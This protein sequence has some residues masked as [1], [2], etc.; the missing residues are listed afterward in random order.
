MRRHGQLELVL[1]LPDGGR[2]LIPA[3]WTDLQPRADGETDRAETLGRLDELKH[4]RL[5]VDS[6]LRRV[7]TRDHV[8]EG[9]DYD[10]E[11]KDR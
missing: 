3:T 7:D 9:L 5:I 8:A 11:E 6:L 4:T 10:H 2:A 1:E